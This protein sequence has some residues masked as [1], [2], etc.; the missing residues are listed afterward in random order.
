MCLG[1]FCLFDL[2]GI[3]VKGYYYYVVCLVLR[4]VCWDFL[5]KEFLLFVFYRWVY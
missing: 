1:Y 5:E 4:D 3:G 2:F